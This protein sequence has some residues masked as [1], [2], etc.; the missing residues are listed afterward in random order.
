MD[1]LKQ[2]KN[3]IESTFSDLEAYRKPTA[4]YKSSIAMRGIMLIHHILTYEE[5]V[6]NITEEDFKDMHEQ[7]GKILTNA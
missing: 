3:I 4:E 5:K 6:A 7:F 1:K 2:I